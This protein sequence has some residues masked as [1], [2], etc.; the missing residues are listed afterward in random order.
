MTAPDRVTISLD[1]VRAVLNAGLREAGLEPDEVPVVAAHLLACELRG[2]HS[3]GIA[4]LLSIAHRL[5][6]KR[7]PRDPVRIVREGP[8]SAAVDG[9]DRVGYL[10]GQFATDLAVRKAGETGLALV[11]A[12]RTWYTGMLSYYAEQLTRRGFVALIASNATPWVAPHGGTEGRFGTNPFCVGFPSSDGADVV[13]DI[14]TS[15]T[16]HAS[17]ELARRTGKSLDEGLALGP[18]GAPTVDPATALAGTLLSWGG[19][20]GSGL[21][22]V[23]Q[24]LGVMAGSPVAPGELE[25]FGMVI[26]A[27]DPGLLRPAADGFGDRVREYSQWVRATRSADG[28]EVRMPFDRTRRVREAI[29][30]RGTLEIEREVLDAVR[31]LAYPTAGPA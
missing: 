5:S 24:L 10:V 21:A 1:E 4:R 16:T 27:W 29:L 22:M 15:A 14:G 30:A 12:S 23:V 7:R 19:A 25:D 9:G 26:A 3:G 18:D 2:F 28:S 31:A 13:W 8:S 6:E 11:G 20:R 17:V